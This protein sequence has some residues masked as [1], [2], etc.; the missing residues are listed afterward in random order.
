MILHRSK[1][2]TVG[3]EWTKKLRKSTHRSRSRG[4][5]LNSAAYKWTG[6]V[7]PRQLFEVAIQAQVGNKVIAREK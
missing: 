6:G 1:C 4:V 5:S 2:V 3:R 7:I